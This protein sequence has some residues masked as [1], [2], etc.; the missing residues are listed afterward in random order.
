MPNV[1]VLCTGNSCRSQ[2]LHGYLARELAGR[3][4]V[5]SAG[6]ETHGLNPRAVQV[7]REDG[8]DIGH[9]RS[10]HVD[11]YADVPFAYLI[12]VCDHARETCPVLPGL[13]HARRLHRSFADPARAT[14]SEEQ[15]LHAFRQVR[16]AIKAYARHVAASYFGNDVITEA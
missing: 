16:D 15:V 12:S 1:L 11:E 10:T 14:G 9:H 4:Q 7:M 8:V 6:V 2:M 13:A 3:A 5:Y